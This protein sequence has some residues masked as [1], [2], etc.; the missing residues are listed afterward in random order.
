MVR[1][2]T[3]EDLPRL[4]QTLAEAFTGDPVWTWMV[5]TL[6][7][8]RRIFTALLRHAIP[9]GHVYTVDNGRSAGSAVAMWA[10]PGQWKLP[11]AA[12]ARA[13]APMVLAT[14]WRLPRLLGRNTAV[15]R[16][17]E[18]VPAQHWYLEFIASTERGLGS[19]L[20]EHG[21]DAVIRGLPIY[22]ESSNPRNLSFYKRHGF[23]V[24]GEPPMSS[25]PP[26]WT[27][28]RS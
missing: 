13:A 28:W 5:P 27:L 3:P 24:T 18:K 25:G 9:K 8:K 14:G 1:Q 26:Q 12:M 11:A 23:E 17:H 19:E 21:V 6:S 4:A 20:M 7:G 15:E 10:P 2:A 16:L 22:L